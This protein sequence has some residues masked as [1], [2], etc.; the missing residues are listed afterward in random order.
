[1]QKRIFVILMCNGDR[2]DHVFSFRIQIEPTPWYWT[3]ESILAP[4]WKRWGKI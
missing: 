3:A 2:I 4:F 1:M